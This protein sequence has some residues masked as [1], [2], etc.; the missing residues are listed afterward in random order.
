MIFIICPGLVARKN[1]CV[2]MNIANSQ[3]ADAH[4]DIPT[5]MAPTSSCS[6]NVDFL[7]HL[8]YL[9]KIRLNYISF[10]SSRTGRVAHNGGGQ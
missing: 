3:N 5:N 9:F 4:R 1:T 7:F 8:V 6:T 2:S 10:L